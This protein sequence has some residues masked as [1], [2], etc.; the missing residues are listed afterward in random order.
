M[1]WSSNSPSPATRSTSS[2][3]TRT[4][5]SSPSC[6]T[7]RTARRGGTYEEAL[8]QVQSAIRGHIKV[9]EKYGDPV[10]E[11]RPP[12][13]VDGSD[14]VQNTGEVDRSDATDFPHHAS[15]SSYDT[16]LR[17]LADQQRA[18]QDLVRQ[19]VNAY[20]YFLG[21]AL[22]VYQQAFQ[23]TVQVAQSS[24]Q[25][26]GQVAQQSVQAVGQAA[27]Q[28]AGA[29][30][31]VMEESASDAV[32]TEQESSNAAGQATQQDQGVYRG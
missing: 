14:P 22:S 11:P 26:A 12:R 6:P 4:T 20:A 9:A 29:A 15:F 7:C 3:R 8:S 17:N 24:M 2:G 23:Q 27:Q 32:Q 31:Q 10:P 21:S 16:V 19:S 28:S 25:T 1:R 5:P 18:A 13:E 30:G